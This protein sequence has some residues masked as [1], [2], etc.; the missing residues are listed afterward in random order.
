MS[1]GTIRDETVHSFQPEPESDRL[2][3]VL[4]DSLQTENLC[5][6]ISRSIQIKPLVRIFRP[7]AFQYGGGPSYDWREKG[8]V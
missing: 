8:A 4:Y 2:N 6:N 1:V 3:S 7:A 5:Q